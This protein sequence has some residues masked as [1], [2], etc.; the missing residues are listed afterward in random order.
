MQRL[1]SYPYIL[2][3][4]DL[5]TRQW[6]CPACGAQHDR[7]INAAKNIL[8]VGLTVNAC[9]EAVRPGRAMPNLVRPSEAGI[10]GFSRR[11]RSSESCHSHGR[12]ERGRIAPD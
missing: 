2:A 8:A 7:D 1:R 9:G 4:L 6:T 11:E 3:S 12:R 10:P 5:G